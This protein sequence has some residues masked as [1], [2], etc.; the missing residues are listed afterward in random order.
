VKGGSDSEPNAGK[1][2]QH[3]KAKSY[4]PVS[5]LTISIEPI[6]YIVCIGTQLDPYEILAPPGA[7][8][9]ADIAARQTIFSDRV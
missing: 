7:R 2:V 4:K 9:N 6:E 3:R 1:V 5:Y 8:G